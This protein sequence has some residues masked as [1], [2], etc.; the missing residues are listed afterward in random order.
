MATACKLECIGCH[1]EYKSYLDG[2][3]DLH[4]GPWV[5][6]CM[7]CLKEHALNDMARARSRR[8]TMELAEIVAFVNTHQKGRR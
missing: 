8:K 2:V 6:L 4:L 7:D 3:D 5:D 1:K